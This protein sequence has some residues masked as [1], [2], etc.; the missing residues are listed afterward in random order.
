MRDVYAY[1]PTIMSSNYEPF[2]Q[3]VDVLLAEKRALSHDILAGTQEI[4]LEGFKGL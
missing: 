4:T 3:R 2:D 1:C